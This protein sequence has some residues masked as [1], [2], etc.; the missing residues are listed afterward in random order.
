MARLV[1]FVL[2]V[3]LFW[4]C[5]SNLRRWLRAASGTPP[6]AGSAAGRPAGSAGNGEHA[7]RTGASTGRAQPPGAA[8]VT[9]VRCSSCGVY[10]P[11]TRTLPGRAAGE[12]FCSEACRARGTAVS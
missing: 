8:A 10:V 7:G 3:F 9:L 6:A 4:F 5:W 12:F 2:L 1:D 11:S